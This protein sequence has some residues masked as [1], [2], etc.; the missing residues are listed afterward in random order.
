MAGG[1]LPGRGR[2]QGDPL[3][4]TLKNPPRG[5]PRLGR[6]DWVALGLVGTEYLLT[7]LVLLTLL[8]LLTILTLLTYLAY[9]TYLTYLHGQHVLKLG[10]VD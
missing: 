4:N 5:L 6:L 1:T 7:L 9:L 8:T 10:D 3:G 2:G